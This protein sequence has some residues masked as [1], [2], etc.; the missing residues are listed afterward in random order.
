M[1][2]IRMHVQREGIG[3]LFQINEEG[4]VESVPE[5][6][7]GELGLHERYDLQEWIIDKPRILGEELLI[8]TSE[9]AG[10]ED[11][12]NRLDLLAIDREGTLVVIELKRDRA[13]STVDLQALQYASF[14]STLTAEDIQELYSEFHD[15]R[16]GEDRSRE[17]VCDRF[18]SFL[19]TDDIEIGDDGW[20]QFELDNRPRILIAAGDFGTEITSP[21]LWLYEEYG[22]EI[23]CVRLSA[24]AWE[25]KY[26]IQGQRII[27]VPEAEEYMTRRRE[28]QKQQRGSRRPSMLHL[29]L[30]QGIIK[31][32]D[33]VLFNREL[34]KQ[35]WAPDDAEDQWDP[36]DPLFRAVVTGE[37][38]KS[39]NVKWLYDEEVYSFTGLTK[40]VMRELGADS[41]SPSAGFWYWT[42]PEY[43]NKPLSQLGDTAVTAKSQ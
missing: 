27:P 19:E 16:D 21:V 11:T 14:C 18:L 39:N 32:G 37:T 1:G 38:G 40:G 3:M 29:L 10:F 5:R 34:L 8:I 35:E 31:E 30:D 36:T 2:G 24:Y 26:L 15:N 28:K 12:L 22:V 9:Y 25:G 33:E 17:E 13:D 20:L 43:E 23:S 4:T 6:E 7:F 42:H 41:P